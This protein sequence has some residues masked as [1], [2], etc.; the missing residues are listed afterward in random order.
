MREGESY[1]KGGAPEELVY[2]PVF[3]SV[4]VIFYT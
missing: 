4:Y 1:G 2:P 3:F